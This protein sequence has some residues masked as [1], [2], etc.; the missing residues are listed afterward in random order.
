MYGI[1]TKSSFIF[2]GISTNVAGLPLE[3]LWNT[4]G[5]THEIP[6]REILHKFDGSYMEP[7]LNFYGI[8]NSISIVSLL[9]SMESHSNLHGIFRNVY[10]ICMESVIMA[11]LLNLDRICIESRLNLYGICINPYGTYM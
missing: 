11:S 4:C 9:I 1:S 10:P 8:F 3:S 5:M 6:N 2:Y 7:T